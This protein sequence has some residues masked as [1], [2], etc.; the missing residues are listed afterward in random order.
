VIPTWIY[1]SPID[2][3]QSQYQQNYHGIKVIQKNIHGQPFLTSNLNIYPVMKYTTFGVIK[4]LKN[5]GLEVPHCSLTH[6]FQLQKNGQ[7]SHEIQHITK[8]QG[9]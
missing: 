4:W 6:L 7:F 5:L 2:T 1:T 8:L 9:I 3:S